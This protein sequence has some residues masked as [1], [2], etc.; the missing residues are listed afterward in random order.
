MRDSEARSRLEEN[1]VLS[2]G[3]SPMRMLIDLL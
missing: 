1:T 3:P 2:R